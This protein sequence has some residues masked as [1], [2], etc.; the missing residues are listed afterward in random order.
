MR[1]RRRAERTTGS[2]RGH[3]TRHGRSRGPATAGGVR[4]LLVALVLA[5]AAAH[6]L[7]AQ[8]R[9]E[10]TRTAPADGV[11]EIRNVAGSIGVE[12]WDR[13]EVRVTGTLEDGVEELDIAR[14]GRRTRIEVRLPERG[15]VRNGDADLRVRVPRGSDVVVSTV[16][17]GIEVAEV[18]GD[19]DLTSV[20]G[21]V[22][23]GAGPGAVRAKSISGGVRIEG[24][25][26]EVSASSTSGSVQVLDARG[27]VDASSVSGRVDV[28]GSRF[29]EVE[30]ESVSGGIRFRGDVTP[31]ASV[32][33]ESMSGSLELVVPEDV[34]AE[35]ELSTFSG[36]LS[37]GLGVD[38]EPSRGWGR[39]RDVEFAT[40]SGGARVVLET[41]SGSITVRGS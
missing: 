29:A 11:V 16:S 22:R 33:L 40:G 12:G 30:L 21:G 23:A 10:E 25:R 8:E 19:L 17:A 26:D 1:R 36:S 24:G 39:S 27:T 18:E 13:E 3:G 2:R 7:E 31:D 37:V 5:V 9:V 34:N 6:G 41:F 28:S 32:R 15:N 4:G 35:F 20:S 14:S 38:V